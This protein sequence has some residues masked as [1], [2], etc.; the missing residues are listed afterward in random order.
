MRYAMQLQEFQFHLVR[1]K[2]LPAYYKQKLWTEFQFHLV[3]LKD[4]K[5]VQFKFKRANFNSI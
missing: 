5:H 4:K 2:A 1:L 3:R